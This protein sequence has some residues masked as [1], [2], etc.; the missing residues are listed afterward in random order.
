ME[1]VFQN[2]YYDIID[3]IWLCL[4][5]RTYRFF[6]ANKFVFWDYQVEFFLY[7][8]HLLCLLFDSNMDDT[9]KTEV[10][11]DTSY[12]N[13]PKTNGINGERKII[14]YQQDRPLDRQ[15]QPHQIVTY[16]CTQ[17]LRNVMESDVLKQKS[18]TRNTFSQQDPSSIKS[19]APSEEISYNISMT[20]P[21]Q[22]EI[23]ESKVIETIERQTGVIK[24]RYFYQESEIRAR[25]LSA[26]EEIMLQLPL[27]QSLSL[28]IGPVLNEPFSLRRP[29]QK[30]LITFNIPRIPCIL[31]E[32]VTFEYISHYEQNSPKDRQI[33]EY[34]PVIFLSPQKGKTTFDK[35]ADI[36]PPKPPEKKPK[37]VARFSTYKIF[38]CCARGKYTCYNNNH[39]NLMMII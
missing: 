7:N 24:K 9:Y 3:K 30:E 2:L 21:G 22:F 10:S 31:I 33:E 13:R 19:L 25:L 39:N 29:D 4:K 1:R 5:W 20:K 18:I 23:N 26:Q 28:E 38:R 27:S 32:N 34:R 37:S 14:Y 36:P 17:Q 16:I 12:S 35:L 15:I 6:N 8:I 11:L